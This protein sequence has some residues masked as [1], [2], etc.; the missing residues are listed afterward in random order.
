VA[1]WLSCSRRARRRRECL[2][3]NQYFARLTDE[4]E[5]AVL[6]EATLAFI[7]Q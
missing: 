1:R 3:T 6:A 4:T 5:A 7:D 2:V